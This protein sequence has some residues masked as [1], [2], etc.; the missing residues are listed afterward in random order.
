MKTTSRNEGI[1]Q[2]ALLLGKKPAALG[3]IVASA[4]GCEP[5]QKGQRVV[6][7]IPQWAQDNQSGS[8]DCWQL[9]HSL[10]NWRWSLSHALRLAL[11]DGWAVPESLFFRLNADYPTRAFHI[12]ECLVDIPLRNGST[13][14]QPTSTSPYR[15]NP[16][17]DPNSLVTTELWRRGGGGSRLETM[18]RAE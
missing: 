13:Y 2:A 11:V 14:Y 16:D 5:P 12:G 9:V 7:R 1:A 18:C 17:G 8:T 10:T 6:K 15:W 3:H 4:G